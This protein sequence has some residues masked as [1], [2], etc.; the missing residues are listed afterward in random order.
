MGIGIRLQLGNGNGKE[1]GHSILNGDCQPHILCIV[2]FISK[3]AVG[4]GKSVPDRGNIPAFT[5]PPAEAVKR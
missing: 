2:R 1:C 3:T 5:P 4:G